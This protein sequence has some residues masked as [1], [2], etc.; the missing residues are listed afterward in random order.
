[1]MK[2]GAYPSGVY[3]VLSLEGFYDSHKF[4][5]RIDVVDIDKRTILLNTVVT[6]K[7]V[8]SFIAQAR[9]NKV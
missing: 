2:T 5:A 7:T 3:N 8:K 1:M 9:D 6:I 4:K